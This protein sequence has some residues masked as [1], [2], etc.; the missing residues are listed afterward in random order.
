VL[1]SLPLSTLAGQRLAVVFAALSNVELTS[2]AVPPFAYAIGIAVGLSLPLVAATI[3]IVNASR[4]T[5][6]E[7][8]TEIGLF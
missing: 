8:V 7:A 6:R 5:V 2:D 4:M 1:V 3:P